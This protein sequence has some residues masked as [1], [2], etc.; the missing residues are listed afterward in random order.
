MNQ[1]KAILKDLEM[2][3]CPDD[4]PFRDPEREEGCEVCD[5]SGYI[6][7]QKRFELHLRGFEYD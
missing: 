2:G 6:E 1:L 3:Y 4:C 5:Y 7:D